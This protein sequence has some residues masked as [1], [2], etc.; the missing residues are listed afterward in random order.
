MATPQFIQSATISQY[1]SYCQRERLSRSGE[2]SVWF[3]LVLNQL[4]IAVLD[5]QLCPEVTHPVPD[6]VCEPG[7]DLC[8]I[9]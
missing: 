5:D 9:P 2:R 8:G 1:R 3:E 4:Q 6:C 7:F